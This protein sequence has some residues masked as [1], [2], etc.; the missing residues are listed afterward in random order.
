VTLD[1]IKI[2]VFQCN[3]EVQIRELS[4]RIR[5]LWPL[6]TSVTYPSSYYG[7]VPPNWLIINILVDADNWRW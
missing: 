6:P 2:L 1:R 5:R 3:R 7:P 4:F